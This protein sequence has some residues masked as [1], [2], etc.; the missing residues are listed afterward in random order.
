VTRPRWTMYTVSTS[1]RRE[2][3]PYLIVPSAPPRGRRC[4]G[5][6]PGRRGDSLAERLRRSVHAEGSLTPRHT[7]TGRPGRDGTAS[8]RATRGGR[9]LGPI[10]SEK[11]PRR[12]ETSLVRCALQ[13][14]TRPPRVPP[15]RSGVRH[16]HRV[17]AVQGASRRVPARAPESV[18]GDPAPAGPAA[19]TQSLAPRGGGG[20]APMLT[21]INA[22]QGARP[23]EPRRRGGVGC[24]SGDL[25][26]Q[27]GMAEQAVQFYERAV[28]LRP[29]DAALLNELGI[30]YQAAASSSR[31]SLRS[32]RRSRRTRE[33]GGDLQRGH[34][35]NGARPVRQGP[36]RPGAAP[37]AQ[38]GR[39]GPDGAGRRRFPRGEGAQGVPLPLT[40]PLA[41]RQ[42]IFRAS[43][44]RG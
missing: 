33:L 43:R 11:T 2:R 21:E 19:P 34:H 22:P 4:V 7:A 35:G 24:V 15:R 14:E 42:P 6:P 36:D 17:R 16:P 40:W 3:H 13:D 5:A 38:A 31:P 44:D 32:R 10:S 8:H 29:G 39:P 23:G 9:D 18:V 1:R 37:Q 20:G 30:C 26:Q 28:A 25:Y 41:E 27:G 12:H